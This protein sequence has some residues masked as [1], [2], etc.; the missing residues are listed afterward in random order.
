MKLFS[1]PE[2]TITDERVMNEYYKAGHFS[3]VIIICLI[4]LDYLIRGAILGHY[5]D[6][7]THL[8]II[9]IPSFY[10]MIRL[11][12]K[13]VFMSG[14]SK[15]SKKAHILYTTIAVL[16]LYNII[17]KFPDR[18][19]N[20]IN[21]VNEWITASIML[22]IIPIVIGVS[23]IFGFMKISEKKEEK[24]HENEEE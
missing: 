11:A 13:G 1:G 14:L 6:V 7:K 3:Y 24:L 8:Y 15:K 9:A 4:F 22:I 5:G 16:I 17:Y 10:F 2:K 19:L 21:I 18:Y 23:I 20:N 12:R